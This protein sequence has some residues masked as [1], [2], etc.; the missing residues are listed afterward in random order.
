MT[1]VLDMLVDSRDSSL[2]STPS[3]DEGVH[4]RKRI[5]LFKGFIPDLNQYKK[6]LLRS[7]DDA[8]KDYSP[9]IVNKA[10][11][12]HLDTIMFA[13][14]MNRN[15][16]L[17]KILQYDF[18]IYGISPKKRFGWHKRTNVEH[19]DLICKAFKC[20]ETKAADFLEILS[21][22]DIMKIK[23]EFIEGGK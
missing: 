22:E 12:M 3:V 15:S 19:L 10:M 14:E 2:E 17:A 9:F 21:D 6:N 1:S 5:D 16:H 4:K 20:N 11:S 13:N 7:D 18:Y 23:N 8:H